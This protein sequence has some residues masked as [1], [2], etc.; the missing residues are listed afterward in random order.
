MTTVSFPGLGL[1]LSIDRVAFTV[2]PLTIYWYGIIVV[3]GIILAIAYAMHRSREFGID[4]DKLL[5]VAMYSVI[6]GIVGARIYYVAFTWDYYKEHLNEIVQIWNGG[7]AF[8]G[9]IIGALVCAFLL[10][11]L[12]KIPFISATDIALPC[13]LLGQGI[14]RWGNFMNVEAFGSYTES[15]LRMVSPR[16]DEYLHMH[17]DLLPGFTPEEVLA[18]TDIPVHPT[19]LYESVWL[20]LGF[21]VIMLYSKHRRFT[22]EMTLMYFAW[23]G[24]GRMFI[25]GLRT[26]SLMIGFIRVSQALAIIL[27]V[28]SAI[29]LLRLR[30]RVAEGTAPAWT[31]LVPYLEKKSE[32]GEAAEESVEEPGSAAEELI[33][34]EPADEPSDEE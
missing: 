1:D 30:K 34:D 14:G 6:A 2:G 29:A 10:C 19:F 32:A 9:G 26:D 31:E 18:M 28:V 3:S 11:K 7:I 27:V 4:P 33:A 16:V 17:P 22:G 13:V 21:I 15:V 25:E 5:D 24:F 12:W 8:Y 23:N 20:I